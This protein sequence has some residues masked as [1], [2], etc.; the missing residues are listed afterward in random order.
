MVFK[1][2]LHAGGVLADKLRP[3]VA[4]GNA[5]V[6]AIPWNAEAGFGAI[7]WDGRGILNPSL[8]AELRVSAKVVEECIS[9]T[10]QI[11]R[12]RYERLRG[13]RPFPDL[14]GRTVILVDYGLASGF[15]M[16]GAT[17]SIK[18]RHPRKVIIAVPTGSADG[19]ALLAPSV[20]QLVCPHVRRDPV[21]AVADAYE[22]WYDL[23]DDEAL[24]YFR[25]MEKS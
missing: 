2:S 23:S 18:D 9:R 12:E 10:R 8:V 13:G 11:T 25:G 19:V 17:E 24:R 22:N 4:S 7:T 16:L 1:D 3:V 21:F 15:S 20:E 14:S 6:P 5:L